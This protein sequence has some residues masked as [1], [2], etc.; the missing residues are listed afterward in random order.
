[1]QRQLERKF[2]EYGAPMELQAI[3]LMESG[4]R[5]LPQRYNPVKAAGLWQFIPS[6]G[7]K[8]GLK[9]DTWVDERLDPEK[10]TFAEVYRKRY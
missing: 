8:F 6:T 7:Y 3:A 1:M 9:R 4:Y 10:A 5:N 2:A